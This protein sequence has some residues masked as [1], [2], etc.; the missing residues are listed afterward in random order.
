[1][2]P[3]LYRRVAVV[4]G[5]HVRLLGTV[6]A[7]SLILGI[8]GTPTRNEP[9]RISDRCGLTNFV[10]RAGATDRWPVACGPLNIQI[11]DPLGLGDLQTLL[12]GHVLVDQLE[13]QGQ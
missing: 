11:P 4:I 2:V 3:G 12:L 1:M 7:N 5:C 10:F 13:L 8:P 6:V 9:L